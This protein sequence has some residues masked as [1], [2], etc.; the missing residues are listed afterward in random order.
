MQRTPL[1]A[2]NWKMN[3]SR[4]NAQKLAIELATL[5]KDDRNTGFEMVVCPPA[6]W[7]TTVRD[8]LGNSAI[9]VGAQTCHH[10]E[11]GAHTGD[12]SAE[13]LSDAGCDYVIL[14]HSERRTDHGEQDADVQAQALIANNNGLNTIICVG[15]TEKQR[16]SGQAEDVVREQILGSLPVSANAQNTVIAYEPVWAIGTGKV[17]TPDDVQMIHATIRQTLA[18]KVGVEQ[19]EGIRILYGG[20]MKPDNATE[21]LALKDVDG[22]LVGGASLKS[23]DFW[24]IAQSCPSLS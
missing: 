15:E 20:S 17:A 21:L 14:G 18:D 7:I 5:H 24:G 23:E 10:A 12:L 4:M 16:E 22:G 8:S 3:G 2:G 6:I 1:I 11:K 19:A 13:M 9:K